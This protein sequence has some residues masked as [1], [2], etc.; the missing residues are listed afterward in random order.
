MFG[1]LGTFNYSYDNIYLADV[2]IRLDGNSEFGAD[3][4]F[5][6]FFSG[7]LGLN[8]HNYS[9][10][11]DMEWLERLKIRTTYGV[12]GKVNFSPYDAQTMYRIINDNWYKTGLGAS[13]I[14]LGNRN[15]GWEKTRNWD[16][17]LDLNILNGLIQLDFSY[18]RKKTVDLV[19]S[20]TLPSS[21]GFTSYK[22]N[23]GEVMNKGVEIQ[24]RS[25]LFQNKDWL[26]ALFANLGHNKNEILKI[27]DSLKD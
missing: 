14:A 4:R 20:V 23:I 18:Y 10:M 16:L 1:A 3:K 13:L 26:V 8:I 22:D 11:K 2:S 12:T 19:N 7:G 21:T 24:L 9:F 27:S 6:P 17:G 25:N 5:A 15:L